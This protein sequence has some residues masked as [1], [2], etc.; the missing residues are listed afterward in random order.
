MCDVIC[1]PLKRGA[2]SHGTVSMVEDP[3]IIQ[4]PG[5]IYLDSPKGPGNNQGRELF[6]AWEINNQ[7]NIVFLKSNSRGVIYF[8]VGLTINRPDNCVTQQGIIQIGPAAVIT[9]KISL[10]WNN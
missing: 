9:G 10:A 1:T 7:G 5:I 6:K 4:G 8:V 2:E 3:G